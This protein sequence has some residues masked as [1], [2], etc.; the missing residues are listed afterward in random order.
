MSFVCA[1]LS[2]LLHPPQTFTDPLIHLPYSKDFLPTG[3]TQTIKLPL[4]K[5]PYQ[6]IIIRLKEV[7]INL[8]IYFSAPCLCGNISDSSVALV[9]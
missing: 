3:L 2:W 1:G 7:L 9:I 4:S 6:I 8:R 5:Y